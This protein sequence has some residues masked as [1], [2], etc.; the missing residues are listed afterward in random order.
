MTINEFKDYLK[1][2]KSVSEEFEK[3]IKE[4]TKDVKDKEEIPEITSQIASKVGCEISADDIRA[5]I[6]D[7]KVEKLSDDLL[8]D[9]VGGFLLFFPWW[10]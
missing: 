6:A 9:V 10:S 1:N 7:N 8:E 3:L 4:A 5:Y 2:N